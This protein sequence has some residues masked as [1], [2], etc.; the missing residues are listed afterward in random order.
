MTERPAINYLPVETA[1]SAVL[2]DVVTYLNPQMVRALKAAG[3]DIIEAQAGA[4]SSGLRRDRVS[5]VNLSR[6]VVRAAGG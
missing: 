1:N 6:R 5:G 2:A 3:L 4:H